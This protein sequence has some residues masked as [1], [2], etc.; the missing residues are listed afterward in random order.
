[1]TDGT[2]AVIA[3]LGLFFRVELILTSGAVFCAIGLDADGQEKDS[4]EQVSSKFY[5]ASTSKAD[6][7]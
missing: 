1:M 7:W 3:P 6:R 4:N 5:Q 2:Y